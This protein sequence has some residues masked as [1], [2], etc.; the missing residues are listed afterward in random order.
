MPWYKGLNLVDFFHLCEYLGEASK[1]CAANDPQAWP[2]VQ[3]DRLKVNQAAAILDTLAPFVSVENADDPVTAC[4]H[5]LRNRLD[6]LDDQG[7]LQRGLPIGSGEIESAH[8][9]IIQNGSSSPARGGRP[10]ISRRC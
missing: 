7:A 3:K 5:Y 2:D 8:R 9:Y 4:D 10:I 1:I 6:Q